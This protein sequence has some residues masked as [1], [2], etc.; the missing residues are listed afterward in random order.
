[1]PFLVRFLL[2]LALTLPLGACNSGDLFDDSDLAEIWRDA[3]YDAFV[4]SV[5]ASGS[6]GAALGVRFS[7]DSTLY[8]VAGASQLGD[9][10]EEMDLD[11]R[12]RMGGATRAMVAVVALQ[13]V[14]ENV[15]DL[16]DTVEDWLPGLLPRGDDITVRMLLQHASGLFDYTRDEEFDAAW[17]LNWER[18]WT[19]RELVDYSV[20]HD[21][22]FEPGENN[23]LSAT[24]YVVLGLVLEQATGLTAA[25]LLQDRILDPLR[26]AGTSLPTTTALPDPSCHGYMSDDDDTTSFTSAHDVSPLSP[27]QAWTAGGG[28]STV[29]D[30]LL[31]ANHLF[32]GRLI[33]SSS[34]NEQFAFDDAGSGTFGLGVIRTGDGTVGMPGFFPGYSTVVYRYKDTE[35]V[36]MLNSYPLHGSINDVYDAVRDAIFD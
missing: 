28:V 31:F 19:P 18:V 15:L 35:F 26:L 34:Y 1:M 32:E 33:S 22:V 6:P 23:L 3:V 30:L 29:E 12:F 13:L 5:E 9:D 36:I 11:D 25:R 17:R 10:Y 2:L 24:D 21:M 8:A 4:D 14:D 7:D 27:T 20:D 16:D